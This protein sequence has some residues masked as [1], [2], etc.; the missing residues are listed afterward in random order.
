VLVQDKPQKLKV[1]LKHEK[2]KR[3]TEK[4]R[5]GAKKLRRKLRMFDL[6]PAKTLRRKEII[7]SK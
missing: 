1:V 3:P 7:I 4:G 6:F 5:F 2:T